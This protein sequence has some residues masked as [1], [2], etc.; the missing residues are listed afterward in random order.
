MDRGLRNSIIA[1]VVGGLVVALVLWA[2]GKLPVALSAIWTAVR[3]LWSVAGEAVCLPWWAVVLAV[4]LVGIQ[5]SSWIA[6][7]WAASRNSSEYEPDNADDESA[8]KSSPSTSFFWYRMGKAFPG[9]RGLR[10]FEDPREA[11]NRIEVLFGDNYGCGNKTPIWWWRGGELAVDSFAKLNDREI[12][13]GPQ[14]FRVAKI[15]AY[16]PAA[17]YHAF[18]YVEV[19]PMESVLGHKEDVIKRQLEWRGYASEEYGLFKGRA[20]SRE[21]FDDG[22]AEIN[23]KVVDMEGEAELRVRY[24]T[25]MNF[26]LAAQGSAINNREFD[27]QRDELLRR[28]LVGQATIDDLV[29]AVEALPKRS[30]K[31]I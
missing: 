5:V 10:V 8:L 28:I 22:S 13:L 31:A 18:V 25:S 14:E 9:L 23:G 7:L 1:T 11:V 4:V 2:F 3:W 6:S 16:S 17:Y 12:L 20:V 19:E 21:E 29:A 15:A 26:I 30:G 24:L 27:S